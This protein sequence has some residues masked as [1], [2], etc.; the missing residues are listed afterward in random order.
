MPRN[1]SE[2]GGGGGLPRGYYPL[3]GNKN[4]LCLGLKPVNRDSLSE[5]MNDYLAERRRAV[6]GVTLSDCISYDSTVV[7]DNDEA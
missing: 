7:S 1:P 4:L 2:K 3:S 5:K 6:A